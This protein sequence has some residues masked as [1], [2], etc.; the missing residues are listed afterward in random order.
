MISRV[1]GNG[2]IIVSAVIVFILFVAGIAVAIVF[3]VKASDEEGG[4][5]KLLKP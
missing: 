5:G 4:D 1:G 2:L 3:A